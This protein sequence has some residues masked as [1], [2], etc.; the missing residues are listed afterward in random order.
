MGVTWCVELHISVFLPSTS[1]RASFTTLEA[2]MCVTA[3]LYCNVNCL[4]LAFTDVYNCESRNVSLSNN[5]LLVF[6]VVL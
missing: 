3:V 2:I 5:E 1:A 6:V 4:A